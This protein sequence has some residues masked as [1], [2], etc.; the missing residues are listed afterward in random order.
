MEVKVTSK[1]ESH[2]E[3]YTKEVSNKNTT[4]HTGS[5]RERVEE[6]FVGMSDEIY[7]QNILSIFVAHQRKY[8]RDTIFGI[9]SM[10]Y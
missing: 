4:Q 10:D 9:N 5:L 2:I 7:S 1:R 6:S 8:L 3:K